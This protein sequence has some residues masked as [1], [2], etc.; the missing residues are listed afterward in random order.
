MNNGTADRKEALRLPLFKGFYKMDHEVSCFDADG[1]V[2]VFG[3][4]EKNGWR[5]SGNRA[6]NETLK[7]GF[8]WEKTEFNGMEEFRILHSSIREDGD[9]KF[10]SII[11]AAGCISGFEGD[12]NSLIVPFDSGYL[13]HCS[14]KE[15]REFEFP[16]FNAPMSFQCCNMALYGITGSGRSACAI[17]E[18]GA[19][20]ASFR[21]RLNYGPEHRY[22]IAA[23]FNLRDFRD[24]DRISGDCVIRCKRFNGGWTEIARFYRDYV[25][26]YRTII[27]LAEKLKGNPVLQYAAKAITVRFRHGVKT[28]PSPIPHQTPEN[29]PEMKIYLTFDMVRRIVE[30]FK[31]QNV[32]PAELNLVGWNYGGH[33]GA[34]PKIFP[35]E[36]RFG[37]EA[38]L[39]RNINAIGELGFP[40]SLHECFTGAFELAAEFG[41]YDREDFARTHDGGTMNEGGLLG[42]GQCMRTCP[43]RVMKYARRNVAKTSRLPIRGSYFCDVTSIIRLYKCYDRN[44]P[45]GCAESVG[46]WKEFLRFIHETFHSSMSEGARE[47]AMPELDRAFS[48]GGNMDCTTLPPWD[49]YRYDFE[50]FD[51]EIPLF[52]MVYHGSLLYNVFR[53]GI[54]SRRGEKVYLRNFSYGGIPLFYYHHLF[55]PEF[56]HMIGWEND[57]RYTTPEKLI[58]NVAAIKQATDDYARVASLQTE[59]IN[60]FIK[61]GDTLTQTVY[62]NGKSVW[63]NYSSLPA[64]TPSGETVPAHDF[65]VE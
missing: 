26:K 16:L 55:N 12:G 19:Y 24:E 34:W 11:P 8:S 58:E 42:G 31:R 60:D 17:L 35:V 15:E 22:S 2:A 14:G 25:M 6:W 7:L 1:N 4:S 40:V 5:L 49:R 51:E 54:N 50:W 64:Q 59:F 48:I 32:G 44:H 9:Y 33:D 37:G 38:S 47:W 21:M 30:E 56:N 62:A 39:V 3:V 65:I 29:Q 61:H 23:V 18:D 10:K 52:E 57:L 53:E 28:V 63:V 45:V 13:V 20:D 36:E 41:E 46:Y 27:P 43:S